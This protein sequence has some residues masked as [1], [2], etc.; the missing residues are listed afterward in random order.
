[1]KKTI[2][3]ILCTVILTLLISSPYFLRLTIAKSL[4][5]EK[6]DLFQSNQVKSVANGLA[7]LK[8]CIIEINGWTVATKCDYGKIVL[9]DLQGLT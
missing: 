7:N 9:Q 3:Q 6:Y 8:A 4:K 1:M 5:I 2:F